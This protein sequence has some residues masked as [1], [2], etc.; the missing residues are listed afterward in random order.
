VKSLGEAEKSELQGALVEKFPNVSVIDVGRVVTR[1]S[2]IMD[3]MSWALKAMAVLSLFCG[4]AVLYSIASH[5]AQSR[6]FEINL[7]KV[8]G[9]P[10]STL[11]ATVSAEFLLVAAFAS[12]VGAA[13]A[14]AFGY[15][16]SVFLFESTWAWRWDVPV[17][18]FA[19]ALV[20][21]ALV[22]WAASRAVFREKPAALLQEL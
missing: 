1:I 12:V 21:C 13:V 9:L 7:L 17:V 8:V 4:A 14:V 18:T 15:F 19:A 16:L 5:H 22:V 20:L 3:Q 2:E 6:R 10:F 11:F